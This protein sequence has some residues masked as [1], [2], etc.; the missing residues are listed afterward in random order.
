[1][2]HRIRCAH[3]DRNHDSVAEVAECAEDRAEH[4]DDGAD[5]QA[6]LAAE[7]ALEDRG[8]WEARAQDDYEARL[9]I[10]SFAQAWHDESPTTCPCCN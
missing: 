6:E 1:M 10:R 8:Y 7:R 3:C 2:A 9:G 5:Y 4:D